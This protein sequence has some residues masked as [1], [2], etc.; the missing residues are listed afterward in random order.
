MEVPH[1]EQSAQFPARWEQECP[2]PEEQLEAEVEAEYPE[3]RGR[4]L[5]PAY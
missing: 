2:E 3:P 4:E 1:L 5:P